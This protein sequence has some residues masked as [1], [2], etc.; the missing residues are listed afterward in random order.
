MALPDGRLVVVRY[1]RSTGDHPVQWCILQSEFVWYKC[2]MKMKTALDLYSGVGGWTLGVQLAEIDVIRSCEWWTAANETHGR[3]F[4]HQL[5]DTDIRQLQLND[6]PSPGTVDFVIGS[7]P[8]TQFSFSNRGGNGDL[9]DGLIDIQKMLEI[10]EH[11]KPKY[12]MMENVPRVSAILKEEL[13]PGGS[14]ARFAHLVTVNEVFDLAEFGLP[15]SRKRMV[16]GNYP[17][18]ILNSYRNL[19]TPPTLG[20]VLESLS[21]PT[22]E[23]PNYGFTLEADKLTDHIKEPVL[24]QEE[25]RMNRESKTFHPVYNKMS[26]PDYVTRPA[27]TV[28]AT[29][30]RVSRESI[31]VYDDELQG[32][33]RLTLREKAT[34]QGFPISY[35]FY[36]TSLSDRQKMVGNAIPPLFTY[37]LGKCLLETPRDNVVI[38][39]R[40]GKV[41]ES[42][43]GLA[44]SLVPDVIKSRYPKTRSFR[45]AI[46]GL[47]FGSGVRFELKNSSDS[48]AVNW[49]VDFYYG[50]SK[51]IRK[52]DIGLTRLVMKLSDFGLESVLYQALEA[53][54]PL[55]DQL[56]QLTPTALQLSWTRE[57]IGYGPYDLV[58]ALGGVC[59]D[60]D[61]SLRENPENLFAIEVCARAMYP[62]MNAKTG[63][64]QMVTM[65]GG[66]LVAAL[67]NEALCGGTT[68][69]IYE[70]AG[71]FKNTLGL[72][73]ERPDPVR[74]RVGS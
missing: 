20:K 64:D 56:S 43:S 61:S 65:F 11:L 7:P 37:F 49:A 73:K 15:Q 71:L 54:T 58:D 10:V 29:C 44:Q 35:Q 26:F 63:H 38:P 18:H 59:V 2:P 51:D 70:R 5:P 22:P 32:F 21:Y 1:G 41:H 55:L 66:G 30:T 12:W 68:S 42:P 23:D 27:R 9:T 4:G 60:F 3:N 34:L 74:E 24:T 36:A 25:C 50:S 46:P 16:A 53:A 47:R 45:A 31:V 62:S 8:C 6:L 14:L 17:L 39:F 19:V 48:D 67:V 69:E 52:A 72:P 13:A 57:A 33:R 40:L 28:T